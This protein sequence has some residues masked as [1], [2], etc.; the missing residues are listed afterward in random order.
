MVKEHALLQRHQRI[1]VLDVG[2]TAGHG[3]LDAPDLRCIERHQR[4]HRG[5]DRLAAFRNAVGRHHHLAPRLLLFLLDRLR[6]AR[7]LRPLEQRAHLHRPAARTD[8]FEQAER[9]QRMTAELEEV[10]VAPHARH[11]EHFGPDGGEHLLCLALRRLVGCARGEC[12]LGQRLAIDLAVGVERHRLQRHDDAGHHVV[13]QLP[14]QLLAQP[15][16][17]QGLAGL[18]RHI[19]SQPGAARAVL[20]DHHRLAHLGL[21]EQ[22]RFDLA[23]LDAKAPHLHLVIDAAQ[24]LQLPLLVPARQV[25]GAVEPPATLRVEGIGNEA[26]GAQAGP[27]EV[28]ARQAFARHVELARHADGRRVEFAVQHAQ[29]Q[30]GNRRADRAASAL[31]VLPRDRPVGH[32]HRRLG[33]AV[34]VDEP[35]LR[36]AEALHPRAQRLGL[37]R[38]AAEDHAA[39]RQA[40]LGESRQ[41]RE[42]PEGRGRLVEHRHALAPEQR[43][44]VFRRAADPVRHHHQLAA[45]AQRTE[46]FPHR[47]VE[48][49]GVEE[50][51]DVVGSEAEPRIGGRQQP[52]HVAV[53][54]LRAL[55]P[56]GGARG[57]DHIG[58]VLQAHFDV[59]IACRLARQ[60]ERVEFEHRHA[61]GCR[62]LIAHRLLREHQR[63][64]AVLDHVGQPVARIVGVQRQVSRTGFQDRE[65]ADHRVGRALHR[66]ADQRLRLHTARQQVVREAVGACVQFAVAQHLLAEGQRGRVGPLGR[67]A[68]EEAV[69]GHYRV[70]RAR[71]A[72]PLR[73][74]L[75]IGRISQREAAGRTLGVGRH[76]PQHLE[77]GAHHPLDGGRVVECRVVFEPAT[78]LR[79]GEGEVQRQLELRAA[80]RRGQ[81]LDLQA[82][83]AGAGRAVFHLQAE[84]DLEQRCAARLA[85]VGAARE[86]HVE[87]QVRMV[88][89]GQHVAAHLPA[90]V[91]QRHPRREPCAEDL[92]R[93]EEAEQP[94]QLL[95]VPA[96]RRHAHREIVLAAV[97]RQQHLP[98]GEQHHEGRA[99]LGA[100]E[101]QQR[102]A[103]RRLEREVRGCAIETQLLG[104]GVVGR[105]L[106]R[107]HLGA[108][109]GIPVIQVALHRTRCR[110]F[111]LPA[112][113]V[114][115]L[116]RQRG[117]VH[118]AG[119]AQRGGVGI[120]QVLGK[121]RVRPRIG[122]DVVQ[123]EGEHVLFVAEVH[124]SRHQRRRHAQVEDVRDGAANHCVELLFARRGGLAAQVD[125]IDGEGDFGL[126]GLQRRAIAIEEARAQH[127]MAFNQRLERALQRIGV[128]R[129]RQ[130]EN[131][132]QVVGRELRLQVLQEPELLLREGHRHRLPGHRACGNGFGVRVLRHLRRLVH[133]AFP[134]KRVWPRPRGARHRR[135]A[136]SAQGRRLRHAPRA[137]MS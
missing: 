96:R 124:Q 105:K 46:D 26:L 130:A 20:G 80:I 36:V 112:C 77:V 37:Q 29:A 13:G 54:Q 59:R 114:R 72:F 97:A 104:T 33:D 11:A 56:A 12:G 47:E 129:T 66:D 74:P 14:A 71:L 64:A 7:E 67:L 113:I 58:Q 102:L 87:R 45:G 117:Q 86:Q 3:G 70:M 15:R 118:R 99:A 134:F 122:D 106:Q 61:A 69:N 115:V 79:A 88:E 50:R 100:A 32:V 109:V 82:L 116:Q 6:E 123:A 94:V 103:Q 16:G 28:A 44:E 90:D 40:C 125:A 73:E 5:L 133:Q 107:G 4:H 17:F 24:V 85:P 35:R 52:R 2:C 111:A 84:H 131:P 83:E 78:H 31:Q 132:R 23:Q 98:R 25:A 68:L 121:N 126:H 30:V 135:A 91:A 43:K 63:C 81:L 75:T 95:A 120:G 21:C 49:V 53:A 55:G 89:R 137:P 60:V 27:P 136:R 39:Q 108:Q 128:Q 101:L 41:A 42:L 62:N 48:G 18:G 9:H 8:A 65:Q 92:G 1:D 110:A 19:G 22:L 127:R 57:V 34:H 93:D 119:R 76:V 51:P 10:V 38:L